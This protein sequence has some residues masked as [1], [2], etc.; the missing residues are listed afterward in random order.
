M[1]DGTDD[2][3]TI[4]NGGGWWWWCKDGGCIVA[5]GVVVVVVPDAPRD[6]VL[7]SGD[8]GLLMRRKNF[9]IGFG[10]DLV[11]ADAATTR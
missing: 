10:F 5:V 4:G 7:L 3:T 1:E 9:A 2:V 11:V 8:L 6:D